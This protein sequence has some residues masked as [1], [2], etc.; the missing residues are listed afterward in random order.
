MNKIK[1]TYFMR[2]EESTFGEYTQS[3]TARP[4]TDKVRLAFKY[5]YLL[6]KLKAAVRR[7]FILFAE[8]TKKHFS[9]KFL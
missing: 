1:G 6:D 4:S 3:L 7:S 8:Q 2:F 9:R 5:I